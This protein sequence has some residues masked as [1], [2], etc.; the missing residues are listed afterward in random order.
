MQAYFTKDAY[1][2]CHQGKD[3]NINISD[4]GDGVIVITKW[5]V[6]LSLANSAEEFTSYAGIEMKM[7]IQDFK[8]KVNDESKLSKYPANLYRDDEVKLTI[9]NFVRTQRLA[10]LNDVLKKSTPSDAAS[11]NSV[12]A[13]NTVYIGGGKDMSLSTIADEDD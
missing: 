4:L 8:V 6:E 7:I 3:V 13:K 10:S 12:R 9:Q 11:G 2:K 1:Q 5:H